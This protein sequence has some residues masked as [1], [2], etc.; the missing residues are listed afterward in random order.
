[1]SQAAWPSLWLQ[2]PWA[3]LATLLSSQRPL[4]TISPLLGLLLKRM[5]LQ[6]PQ[7]LK[8]LPALAECTQLPA[9]G[10][11]PLSTMPSLPDA[12]CMSP[13]LALQALALA[14]MVQL[15]GGVPGRTPAIITPPFVTPAGT[16]EPGAS[17][18]SELSPQ[19]GPCRHQ[20]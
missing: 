7:A 13:S 2:G 11:L 3:G 20:S 12:G 18:M 16:G 9:G 15:Q 19:V 1:M 8:C 4:Q 17:P 14:H 6:L 10:A 5:P